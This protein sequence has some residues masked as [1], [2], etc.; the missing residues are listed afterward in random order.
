MGLTQTT[1]RLLERLGFRREGYLRERW[2]VGAEIN[3]TVFLGLLES[4]WRARGEAT[5]A[6]RPT[7]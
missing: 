1:L 7:P 5:G 2:I 6:Q 4:D 3:D